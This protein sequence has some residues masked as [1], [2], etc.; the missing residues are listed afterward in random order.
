MRIY[1]N[2]VSNVIIDTNFQ[3]LIV[4]SLDAV[5]KLLSAI[6]IN[7]I[8]SKWPVKLAINRC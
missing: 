4:L 5:I 6:E 1:I 3:N 2:R 8:S 7:V